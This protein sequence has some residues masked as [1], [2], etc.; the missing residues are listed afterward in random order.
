VKIDDGLCLFRM[1]VIDLS[2]IEPTMARDFYLALL[3]L[4]A[5]DMIHGAYGV[6]DGM[7]LAIASLQLE[8]LD[9]NEFVATIEDFILAM[10]NHHARFSDF[11]R[12]S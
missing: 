11:H 8:N 10:A 9:Y 5:S 7:V 4:N 12:K 6:A 2:A 1:K 3:E